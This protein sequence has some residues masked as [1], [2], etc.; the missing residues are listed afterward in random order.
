MPEIDQAKNFVE[1]NFK[2]KNEHVRTLAQNF[3][4]T[5]R[6]TGRYRWI[7]VGEVEDEL[8]R[9]RLVIYLAHD[10][11]HPENDK[12]I[13]LGPAFSVLQLASRPEFSIDLYYMRDAGLETTLVERALES[14]RFRYGI[15]DHDPKAEFLWEEYFNQSP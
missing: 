8:G 10:T 12:R 5:V 6:A 1:S 4:N 14:M 2:D 11:E 13:P 3:Y 9:Y 15:P 7:G